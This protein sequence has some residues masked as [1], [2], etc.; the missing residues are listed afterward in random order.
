MLA[1]EYGVHAEVWSVTSYTELRRQALD[2]ERWNM[3]HPLD[4]PQRPYVT[5][6]LQPDAGAEFQGVVVA[7]SDYLKSLPDSISQWLPGPLT[8]LGT[9]G[10]GRSATREELRDFFGVDYRHVVLATLTSLAR[11]G[12][13]EADLA[14]RAMLDLNIDSEKPNPTHV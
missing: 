5:Q 9:D 10:Y 12:L 6:Q 1:T 8:S 3:L 13:I 2:V 11:R 14:Q 7:A 4:D